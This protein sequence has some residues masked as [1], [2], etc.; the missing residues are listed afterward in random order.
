MTS[1]V[2]LDK[3]VTSKQIRN[4][5]LQSI[6]FLKPMQLPSGLFCE[7][8]TGN[9][10]VPH[11]ESLRYSLI[12]LLG[13][14]NA[15]E[16]G[17]TQN[18]DLKTIYLAA[19]SKLDNVDHGLGNLGL[20]LWADSRLGCHHKDHIMDLLEKT[21]KS[22]GGLARCQG[23]EVSWI[24]T[25]LACMVKACSSIRAQLL[26]NEIVEELITRSSSR[27]GLFYHVGQGHPRRW[28]PNFAT[29]IYGIL[30]LA[31]VSRL[32]LYNNI[33]DYAESAARKLLLLQLPD[34]GWPWLYNAK[35]GSIV[36]RYEIYS[37]HQEAMGPMGLLALAEASGKSEYVKAS[38]K[39]LQWIWGWNEM[40][41]VMVHPE[42][43]IIYRSIRRQ[44][45]WHLFILGINI[46]SSAA[47][48]QVLFN[49]SFP[50]ELNATCRPYCLGWLLEAWC[51][52]EKYADDFLE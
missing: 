47:T 46:L 26:L 31:T 7:E 48:G 22:H 1:F 8:M 9:Y 40:K 33:L 34:G 28:F 32:G 51:G 4:L 3:K 37:V 15:E 45:P 17:Y 24:A 23:M 25:G 35:N 49:N 29:E 11:G 36:E 2:P 13:L 50:V 6:E 27:S 41:H 52:R 38:L 16:K 19:L 18:F 42:K 30:A 39:G 43:K 10:P 20:Y 5:I 21:L 14:Q 44:K 12:T